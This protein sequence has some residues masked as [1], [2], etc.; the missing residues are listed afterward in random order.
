MDEVAH[1]NQ[2]RAPAYPC[3]W[4]MSEGARAGCGTRRGASTLARQYSGEV[5]VA[6]AVHL[7]G[8]VVG[9]PGGHDGVDV[10]Q[11]ARVSEAR[12]EPGGGLASLGR[13]VSLERL[14]RLP[15]TS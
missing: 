3:F 10:R 7:I 15:W 1:E 13:A 6:G 8:V 11:G 9:S 5:P 4:G 2:E 12:D 14:S